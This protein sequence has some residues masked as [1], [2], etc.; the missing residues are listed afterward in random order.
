M[1]TEIQLKTR[2][3]SARIVDVPSDAEPD[4]GPFKLL[5]GNWRSVNG[6][7]WNMIAVPVSG[8]SLNYRLQLN[9][10]NEDLKFSIMDRGTPPDFTGQSGAAEQPVIALAYEQS[11]TQVATADRAANGSSTTPN[12]SI[13]Q[14]PG[15]FLFMTNQDARYIDIARLAAAPNGDPALALGR[16]S[17]ST[18]SPLISVTSG[19]PIGGPTDLKSRFL[20]P[21]KHFHTQPF[22][23]QFD[24]YSP[25]ALLRSALAG[26]DIQ[27]TTILKFDTQLDSIAENDLPFITKVTKARA[28]EST[29]WIHELNAENP[30]GSARVLMQYTQTVMVE[31]FDRTDGQPG[32]IK[33]PC[34]SINTLEK[35]AAPRD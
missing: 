22:Q 6:K 4:L 14:S 18:A 5:P 35:I 16:S 27:R 21:Y 17:V 12:L 15:L 7:G 29:F 3:A 32:K 23:G 11:I 26:Q 1:L 30:D 25:N 24:P 28:M 31:F 19:L 9:Q 34:I 8:G 20:E 2:P 13:Q 33:W 10:F